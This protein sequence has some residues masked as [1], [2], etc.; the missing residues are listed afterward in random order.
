M[1]TLATGASTV[2]PPSATE[3]ARFLAQAAFGGNDQDLALVQSKGAS[4]WLDS[5]FLASSDA[6]HWDWM[7]SKGFNNITYINSSAGIDPSLW[8]KLMSSPDLLRQ[9]IALA[10][11][12]VF[13]VSLQGLN[14]SWRA[15]A[16]AGYMDMLSAQAFG[17]FRNLI[18]AV[19]LSP[20]MGLYLGTR[21]NQKESVVTGRQPDENYAREVMQLFTI[22]LYQ[23]NLDGSQKKGTDG[24]PIETYT[25]D[26]VSQLAR[27]FTGWNYDHPVKEVPD[28]WRRNMVLN[29]SLHS[30]ASKSFLGVT[31]PAG[32]NDGVGDLKIVLDTLFNH[33][34][35]PPFFCKQLIQRL[36]TSNPSPAYVQRVAQVFKANAVGVRGDMKAVIR[37]VLLDNEA[38]Q[39]PTSATAGKLR[40]PMLR[41]VQFARTFKATSTSGNWNFGN[42]LDPDSR[43]GQSPMRSPTVF[44]FFRPGFVPGSGLVIDPTIV[45]PELQISTE[46]TVVGYANFMQS[47]INGSFSDLKPDYTAEIALALDATALAARINNMVA[48][49]QISSANLNGIAS[50]VNTI[51]ASTDAGKLNRV[52]ATIMLVMCAPEYI[53]QK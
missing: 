21:G 20:A 18:E 5:Q 26:T 23:L 43:L 29:P 34:N 30:T 7:I 49:G 4:A 44:N 8:R 19:T 25:L 2:A 12:E 53:V 37:A 28:H 32:V 24:K 11:S 16:V 6:S 52:K 46:S 1:S 22:G 17:N 33:P 3:A 45:V 9:R 47:V 51:N 35:L 36:V 27:V 31:I 14:G 40:E 10:L 41:L 50:A 13:V 38:R 39:L 42:T 48:A 15:F